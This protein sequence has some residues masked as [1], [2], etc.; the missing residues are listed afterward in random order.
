MT[1][2]GRGPEEPV[3][4]ELE[5]DVSAGSEAAEAGRDEG[6][7]RGEPDEDQHAERRRV[8][9]AARARIAS[10]LMHRMRNA[11]A[12]LT[13][14]RGYTVFGALLAVAFGVVSFFYYD[15]EMPRWISRLGAMGC[16]LGAVV[17]LNVMDR[18]MRGQRLP[19]GWIGT[20]MAMVAVA[21]LGVGI[22][23]V[24]YGLGAAWS[25]LAAA[26]YAFVGVR[27]MLR[28]RDQAAAAAGEGRD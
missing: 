23:S 20:A 8:T 6:P 16:L 9:D 18:I 14:I 24:R 3:T 25:P 27:I 10:A 15:E 22:G 1:R 11:R 17:G 19:V 7:A 12:A 26:T 21:L 2:A 4:P 13:V 5:G 28:F